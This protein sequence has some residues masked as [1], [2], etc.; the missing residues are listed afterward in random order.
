MQPADRPEGAEFTCAEELSGQ[1]QRR[2]RQVRRQVSQSQP[3]RGESRGGWSDR[4]GRE[5]EER[6]GGGGEGMGMTIQAAL[7]REG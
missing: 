5:G 2:E 1:G 4:L 3:A 6:M 7:Y